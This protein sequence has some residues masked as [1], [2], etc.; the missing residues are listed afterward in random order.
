M[1]ESGNSKQQTLGEA[2]TSNQEAPP[3]F[4]PESKYI[5]NVLYNPI[6]EKYTVHI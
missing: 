6:G 2:E 1:A 3:L 5:T 4:I